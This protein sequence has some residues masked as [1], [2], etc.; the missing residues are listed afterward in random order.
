MQTLNLVKTANLICCISGFPKQCVIWLSQPLLSGACVRLLSTVH[1]DV[2]G[3]CENDVESA[4]AT[5]KL[6]LGGVPYVRMMPKLSTVAEKSSFLKC[7]VAGYPIDSI[8]T[9]KD[10]VR[11]PM[12]N[13]F[14]TAPYSSRMCNVPP[15][16]QPRLTLLA[17]NPTTRRNGRWR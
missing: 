9:E 4:Q 5:A 2:S 10:G 17:T 7:P 11:M 14:K 3:Y 13:V 8:I 15:I 16:R 6:R 12:K 1:R